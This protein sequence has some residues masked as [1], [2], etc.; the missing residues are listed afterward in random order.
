MASHTPSYNHDG[1]Q[2]AEDCRSLAKRAAVTAGCVIVP[3]RIARTMIAGPQTSP[4]ARYAR[5]RPSGNQ[6]YRQGAVGIDCGGGARSRSC[7]RPGE[8]LRCPF[9]YCTLGARKQHRAGCHLGTARRR[10]GRSRSGLQGSDLL[11]ARCTAPFL[12]SRRRRVQP[13][14]RLARRQGTEAVLLPRPVS[15]ASLACPGRAGPSRCALPALRATAWRTPTP[16]RHSVHWRAAD[17]RAARKPPSSPTQRRSQPAAWSIARTF[18][19]PYVL[20]SPCGNTCLIACVVPGRCCARCV[21][22]ACHLVD[23]GPEGQPAEGQQ[24]QAARPAAACRLRH[25]IRP[26]GG[27]GAGL[28]GAL[29]GAMERRTVTGSPG[30]QPQPGAGRAAGATPRPAS[31]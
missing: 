12:L 1:V 14:R 25:A 6:M 29:A 5:R 16:A 28:G 13:S 23:A 8:V 22:H 21:A 4:Y 30:G 27:A 7:A 20:A 11:A 3:S 2:Q 26:Y 18:C 19:P 31:G 24:L 17:A 9:V 15:T 10:Y